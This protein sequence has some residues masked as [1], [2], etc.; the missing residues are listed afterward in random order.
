MFLLRFTSI[1]GFQIFWLIWLVLKKELFTY[2]FNNVCFSV[3]LH[4]F[5]S[6]H[7]DSYKYDRT[8]TRI[9]EAKNQKKEEFSAV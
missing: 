7:L 5:I 2:I 4:L 6:F 8:D 1:S 9:S 3:L